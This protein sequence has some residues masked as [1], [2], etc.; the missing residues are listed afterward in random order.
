LS[1]EPSCELLPDL[2]Q[3][4]IYRT[5]CGVQ[6]AVVVVVVVA[7]VLAVPVETCGRHY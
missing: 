1:Y 7:V 4:L 2:K 6:I 5:E 3:D